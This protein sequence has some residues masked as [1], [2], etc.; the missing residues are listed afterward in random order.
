MRE[1]GDGGNSATAGRRCGK[2]SGVQLFGREGDVERK[3]GLKMRG[4]GSSD[5]DYVVTGKSSSSSGIAHSNH[6]QRLLPKKDGRVITTLAFHA[7]IPLGVTH[8]SF[9]CF[10]PVYHNG[11]LAVYWSSA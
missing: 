11:C 9:P 10:A 4:I 6:D 3:L 5:V 8:I 2:G 7:G 1:G